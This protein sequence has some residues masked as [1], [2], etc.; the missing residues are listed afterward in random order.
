MATPALAASIDLEGPGKR[1][2]QRTMPMV[3]RGD[4]LCHTGHAIADAGFLDT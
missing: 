4:Y 3:K 1:M 2:C